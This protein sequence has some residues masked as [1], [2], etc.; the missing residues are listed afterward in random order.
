GFRTLGEMIGRVDRI[1]MRQA[2]D[3]WKAAGVDLSKILYAKP[4]EGQAALWNRD[5][6]DHG[7]AKALDHVLI[8]DAQAA[9]EDGQPV[10]GEYEVL[11]VNRTVGAML[12][13]EVAKRYGHAGLPEDTISLSFRG[14]AG[15]SF[16]AFAA[17]GVSLTLIG[18]GNDYV[19]K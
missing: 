10:R 18:D 2:V 9:L 11:N 19:G 13:G 15:Q 7:L 12:S 17:R 3:H 5:R 16:G 14:Q 4:A 1:D 6:Q 8:K